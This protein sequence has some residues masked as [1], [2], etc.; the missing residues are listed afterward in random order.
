MMYEIRVKGCLDR[1]F[2]TGRFGSMQ[3]DIDESRA[4]TILHGPVTDQA[5][6]FGLLSR[7]RDVGLVLIS[8]EQ[9]QQ[10]SQPDTS[11]SGD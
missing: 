5:E 11:S 8:V 7:L 1:N 6:L 10:D 2:W 3:I 4:E 9:A